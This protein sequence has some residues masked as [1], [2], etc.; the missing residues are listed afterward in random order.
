MY[1]KAKQG[2][3]ELVNPEKFVMPMDEHMKSYKDGFLNYKSGLELTAIRYCDFNKHVVKF[4]L[5]PFAIKYFKPETGK[6]HRYYIDLFIEFSN[7]ERFLVEVKSY[8]ETIPPKK[9]R[10]KTQKALMNYQKALITYST[11]QAKWN[12]AREFAKKNN[13]KFIILTENELK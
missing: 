5:E 13:L 12:A 10:K 9:P 6:T 7:R 1:K 3:Y 2:W 8:G 4:S 11:N